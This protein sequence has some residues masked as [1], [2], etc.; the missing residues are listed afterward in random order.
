MRVLLFVAL[1]SS[2]ATHSL[3][4]RHRCTVGVVW[5]PPVSRDA[6]LSLLLS[7]L[8]SGDCGVQLVRMSGEVDI[9]SIRPRLALALDDQLMH[10]PSVEHPTPRRFE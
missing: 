4:L 7:F 8:C 5:D 3:S 10:A 1:G 6:H 2:Y 9:V